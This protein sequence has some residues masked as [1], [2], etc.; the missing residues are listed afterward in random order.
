MVFAF[1][2]S[3]AV[4]NPMVPFVE[5]AEVNRAKE[6]IPGSAGEGLKADRK[7]RQDVGHVHPALEPP[8]AAVGRDAPDLEVLGIRE[9]LEPRHVQPI[10]GGIEPG[11]PALMQGL[12]GAH[13]VE[14][15]PEG[16]EAPLLGS[17]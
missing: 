9:R 4:V 11:W 10:R 12:V 15:M 13:L 8:N 5:P 1:G 17:E 6:D 14:G 3:S 16:V 7:R 2:T